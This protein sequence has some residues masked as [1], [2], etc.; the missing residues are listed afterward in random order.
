MSLDEPEVDDRPVQLG[1]DDGP[2][3]LHRGVPAGRTVRRICTT[4]IVQY[5]S[6]PANPAGDD[7]HG[8]RRVAHGRAGAP[9]GARSRR[10]SPSPEFSARSRPYQRVRR[11]DRRDIYLFRGRPRE[12]ATAADVA[13]HFRLHPNVARHH[14]DKLTAGG[15]LTSP[16]PAARRPAARRSATA[17]GAAGHGSTSRRATRTSWPTSWR[18]PSERP[19]PTRRRRWPTPSASSTAGR[20]PPAW[21]RARASAR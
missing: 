9:P 2:E 19:T 17:R 1:V 20:W 8:G 7:R 6:C 21:P 16:S 4:G 18:A 5:R 3:G 13:R 10:R 15:Y 14:L 12:G 11:S